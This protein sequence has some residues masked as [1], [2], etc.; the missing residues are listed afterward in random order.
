MNRINGQWPAQW[1]PEDLIQLVQAGRRIEL[2]PA[3]AA[4][5]LEKF[6]RGSKEVVAL[7]NKLGLPPEA[8]KQ[9]LSVLP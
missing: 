9:V 3:G 8:L 6:E 1:S 4:A 7:I 5:E 2:N